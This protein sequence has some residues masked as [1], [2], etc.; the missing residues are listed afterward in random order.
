MESDKDLVR[1][2]RMKTTLTSTDEEGW[3]L[4]D[5][6]GRAV[7]NRFD[8][9]NLTLGG[10]PLAFFDRYYFQ[11]V[12]TGDDVYDHTRNLLKQIDDLRI[13]LG[14]AHLETDNMRIQRDSEQ[15]EKERYKEILS[16]MH[17]IDEEKDKEITDLRRHEDYYRGRAQK[18]E[19]DIAAIQNIV[20]ENARVRVQS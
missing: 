20:N 8:P 1:R 16:D 12:Y 15:C 11:R 7:I 17:K 18:L 4:C 2:Y 19:Q 13:E 10:A 5:L 9:K 14:N 3:Y 6:Y